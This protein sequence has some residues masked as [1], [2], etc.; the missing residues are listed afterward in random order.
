MRRLTQSLLQ[1]PVRLVIAATGLVVAAILAFGVF[2]IHTAFIDKRV[3]EADPFAVASAPAPDDDG[4]A[5]PT[6]G[7]S[8]AES[9]AGLDDQA[10]SGAAGDETAADG[11]ATTD[12]PD[13]TDTDSTGA[14][15]ADSAATA[16]G[17]AE[18]LARGEFNSLAHDGEG[19]AV[20]LTDGDRRVLRFEDDFAID[21]GPDLN[22]YLVAGADADGDSGTFDD[23]FVDLGN[24]KGNLGSQ[25]YEIPDS[26]DLDRYDTV[27]IWCVRFAVAF[28][29]ADLL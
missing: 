16:S 25:N 6:A 13:D 27:V 28:N 7:D 4:Q 5:Q 11:E 10:A 8:G 19:T 18:E 12:G 1:H 29:A 3:T 20:I 14:A 22:V 21:N 2:G 9:D 26:V 17:S 23:D 24:L 15:D